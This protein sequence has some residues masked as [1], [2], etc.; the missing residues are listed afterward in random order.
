MR[1]VR[2]VVL[3]L[4]VFAAQGSVDDTAL[5]PPPRWTSA[6]E[7]RPSRA[8]FALRVGTVVVPLRVLAIPVEPGAT[9]PI[10][11]EGSGGGELRLTAGGGR[12]R[13]RSGGVWEWR[14]PDRPGFHAV[15]VVSSQPVDTIHLTFLV[16]HPM[17]EV[18]NGAL[19]GYAIGN[20]RARPASMTAA[21]E[22]PR[23]LV[24]VRPDDYDLLVAPNFRLG[25]FICKQPGDPRYLLVSPRL[26]VKL[27]AILEALNEKGV[28]TPG[29]T[30]MSGYRTPAY[31]RAIGN[32]TDFSRHLWGDA[33][34]IYV[35]ADGDDQMDDLNG[36][37]SSD[38]RDARWL[39]EVVEEVMAN[40]SGLR[41]GGLSVYRRNAAHGPFVHVDSRGHRARW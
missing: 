24:E 5:V 26:L 22:P 8:G 13:E 36:D 11:R 14:A 38:L 27:E 41:P 12:L 7:A 40:G 16:T 37:G 28:R 29:L 30:V 10:A 1:R 3:T 34:D 4:A 35:D 32:T 39:S 9:V 23:G 17:T 21:Y 18:R 2:W 33:A 25:Q 19:N 31:N 15:R 20:Y 6:D